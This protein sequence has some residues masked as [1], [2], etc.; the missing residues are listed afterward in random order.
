MHY[1]IKD[2]IALLRTEADGSTVVEILYG[3]TLKEKCFRRYFSE[4]INFE[5]PS[6]RTRRW[7]KERSNDP[8]PETNGRAVDVMNGQGLAQTLE[9]D[10]DFFV[11]GFRIS[12]YV[13]G[14]IPP[15]MN[16]IE[17]W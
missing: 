13:L 2:Q 3:V 10:V 1:E 11:G 7:W 14:E 5:A 6:A 17:G 9:I 15:G 16:E 8:L 12:S 4:Y